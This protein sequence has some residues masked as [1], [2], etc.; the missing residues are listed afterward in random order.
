MRV[1]GIITARAGSKGLKNKNFLEICGEPMFYHTVT[2]ARKSNLLTDLIVSTDDENILNFCAN[3]D[4]KTLKR[5]KNLAQDDSKIEDV[6]I[7]AVKTYEYR[8]EKVDIIVWMQADCPYRDQT[9]LDR[10]INL[11]ITNYMIFDSVSTVEMVDKRPEWLKIEK[12]KLLKPY[13]DGKFS[14]NRQDFEKIYRPDG[15]VTAIY[16]TFLKMLKYRFPH[17]K[18]IPHTFLGQAGF[19]VQPKKYTMSIDTSE[20]FE[21]CETLMKKGDEN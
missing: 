15:H 12:N 21:I 7:H 2:A 10:A 19:I 14:S 6:L 3:N 8:N 18:E 11:L 1:L 13:I 9:V 20:D 4:V 17:W 16:R 5:P